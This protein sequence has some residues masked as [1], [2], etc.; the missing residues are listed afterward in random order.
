MH[1]INLRN[2]CSVRAIYFYIFNTGTN[3]VYVLRSKLNYYF[4]YSYAVH[5]FDMY[6]PYYIQL[7]L[8]YF[9]L[10]ILFNM[11]TTLHINC[12]YS[13]ILR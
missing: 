8:L 10:L 7:L 11:Y 1:L 3:V 2:N 13:Y 5:I 4:Q 6:L 12:I 9:S